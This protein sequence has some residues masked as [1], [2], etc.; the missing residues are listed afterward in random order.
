MQFSSLVPLSVR[1]WSSREQNKA[2]KPYLKIKKLTVCGGG[3]NLKDTL[4]LLSRKD[5]LTFFY[6]RSDVDKEFCLD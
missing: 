6:H 2:V 4:L 3:R 5:P 1:S